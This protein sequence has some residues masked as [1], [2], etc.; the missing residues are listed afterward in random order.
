MLAIEEGDHDPETVNAVFR[1]V[2]S[3]KGGA[4]AFNLTE[5]VHF[6]HTFENAMDMVRTG[7]LSP[8]GSVLKIMLRAADILA[9]L[10]RAA[11]DDKP[12][13]PARG[14]A[15][16]A[17]LQALAPPPAPKAQD[18]FPDFDFTPVT[19]DLA[20]FGDLDASQDV[21]PNRFT[22]KFRPRADLYAKGNETAVLLREV[23]LLGTVEVVCDLSDL[24][25]LDQLD[26]E[27]AYLAWT[28]ELETT[29]DEAAI[30]EIFDFVEWDSTLSIER[31]ASAP[32]ANDPEPSLYA[33]EP[34]P[35]P[36]PAAKAIEAA[37]P[38]PPAKRA[39][40]AAEGA[41]ADWR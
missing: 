30:R 22:I 21:G 26:P 13:D 36:A 28:I 23:S 18:D 3:I 32:A 29:Q 37:P 6:A 7:K 24:P 25:P 39:S 2:H 17:E 11:R 31:A 33:A 8:S 16:V 20:D 9:D 14:V 34:E 5:L 27:G 12:V 1:A 10:V 35:A 15:V 19:V 38:P 40:S 41:S 4:G